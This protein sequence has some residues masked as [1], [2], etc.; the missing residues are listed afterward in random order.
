MHLEND[1]MRK[2]SIEN[3]AVSNLVPTNLLEKNLTSTW[4]QFLVYLEC[5]Q[6]NQPKNEYAQCVIKSC[7][8]KLYVTKTRGDEATVLPIPMTNTL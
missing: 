6:D 1:G 2:F 8:R 3:E 7:T 5:S 4:K